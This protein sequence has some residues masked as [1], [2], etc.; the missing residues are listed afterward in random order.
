MPKV[1]I[2]VPRGRFARG[3]WRT[4]RPGR[5]DELRLGRAANLAFAAL[6]GC[7]LPGDVSA[8]D[9][10]YARDIT[11]PFRLRDGHVEVPDGPGLGVAPLPDVLDEVTESTRLIRLEA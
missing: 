10:Y 7:A 3:S 1:S 8:S 5:W 4:S 9:R 2:T 11:E 6:P